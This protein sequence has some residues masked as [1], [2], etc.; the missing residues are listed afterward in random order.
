MIQCGNC[1]QLIAPYVMHTFSI[2]STEG[3]RVRRYEPLEAKIRVS[4][5]EM[6]SDLQTIEQSLR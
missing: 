6:I 2:V 1:E 5:D 4:D 3:C